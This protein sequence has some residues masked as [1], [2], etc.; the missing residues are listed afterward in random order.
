MRQH[1][2]RA[3]LVAGQLVAV[4]VGLVV[5]IHSSTPVIVGD[6]SGAGDSGDGGDGCY[7]CQPIRPDR[8]ACCGICGGGACSLDGYASCSR[9][10]GSTCGG[11][12]GNDCV[13][14]GPDGARD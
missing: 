9:A 5:C 6:D 1:A 2:P 11:H 12:G 13:E 4:S 3:L 8:G 14:C 7:G 10:G